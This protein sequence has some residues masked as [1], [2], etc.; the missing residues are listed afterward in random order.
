MR[1]RSLRPQPSQDQRPGR[2]TTATRPVHHPDPG[3]RT[4]PDLPVNLFQ[5]EVAK[6]RVQAGELTVPVLLDTGR[7]SHLATCRDRNRTR[8]DSEAVFARGTNEH[9]KLPRPREARPA[10]PHWPTSSPFTSRIDAGR[11]TSRPYWPHDIFARGPPPAAHHEDGDRCRATPRAPERHRRQS[12]Y[13]NR[14]RRRTSVGRVIRPAVW[15]LRKFAE[16]R[17]D[18]VGLQ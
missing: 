16:T 4:R 9:R 11:G 10:W 15:R 17:T 7:S 13:G 14:K 8:P 12:R 2:M 6:L 1:T 18:A 5:V 3:S